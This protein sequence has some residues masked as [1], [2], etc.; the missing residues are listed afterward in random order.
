[1]SPLFRCH[2]KHS[3]LFILNNLSNICLGGRVLTEEKKNIRNIQDELLSELTCRFEDTHEHKEKCIYCSYLI[4][5]GETMAR[6]G[7]TGDIIHK[8]CWNDYADEYFHEL[9]EIVGEDFGEG[10]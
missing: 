10:Y 3:V 8:K 6:V 4:L 9:C 7:M 2:K 5:P 1:M